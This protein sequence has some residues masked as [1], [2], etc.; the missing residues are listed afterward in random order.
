MNAQKTVPAYPLN[1]PADLRE[2]LEND[3]RVAAMPLA[4]AG[5]RRR[6]VLKAL[7][8]PASHDTRFAKL[9]LFNEDPFGEYKWINPPAG[10]YLS[11]DLGRGMG[12]RKITD[13]PVLYEAGPRPA[14]RADIFISGVLLVVS[15]PF[16]DIV[17]RFDAAAIESLPVDWR[18]EDQSKLDGYFYFDV[19]RQLDAFDYA[20]SEV[21]VLIDGESKRID[22]LN[23]P[24]VL[25][26]GIPRGVHLLRDSY[27]RSEILISVELARA[28]ADAGMRGFTAVDQLSGNTIPLNYAN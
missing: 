7:D 18:F 20:H 28:L 23:F 22:G 24:R 26:N 27:L 17:K 21:R 15:A 12:L 8:T 10:V 5:R 13:T 9:S 4:Q 2:L 16:L 19:T 11:T 6:D 3:P 14:Q 1:M 25:K